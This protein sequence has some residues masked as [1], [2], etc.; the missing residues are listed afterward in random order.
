MLFITRF[1]PV[2][3]LQQQIND[4]NAM[5]SAEDVFGLIFR[6]RGS[7]SRNQHGMLHEGLFTRAHAGTKARKKTDYY[8]YQG[9]ICD[10]KIDARFFSMYSFYSSFS[11]LKLQENE[12][13]CCHPPTRYSFLC[14]LLCAA[15][16]HPSRETPR[17]ALQS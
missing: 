15:L 3:V 8:G 12:A 11:L 14:E 1:C 10:D 4:L 13:R 9:E 2:Q 5:I 16:S 6:L 17:K 7:L